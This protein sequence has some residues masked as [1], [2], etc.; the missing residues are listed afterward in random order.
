[1]TLYRP[2]GVLSRRELL[3]SALGA[4]STCLTGCAQLWRPKFADTGW[5]NAV[6]TRCIQPKRELS[7]VS[8]SEIVQYVREAETAGARVRAV[9]AGHSFSDVAFADGW[10]LRTFGLDRTIPLR[11]DRLRAK[12]RGEQLYQ[13]E[14]GIRVRTLNETLLERGLA[15]PNMGGWDHQTL[16]G[17]ISTSTHG[18]GLGYGP[19]PSLVASLVLVT[20]GGRVV[21]FEPSDGITDPLAFHNVVETPCG[22]YPAILVQDDRAFRAALVN[23]GSLGITYSLVL[24]VR[25]AFWLHEERAITTW[26]D[27][28]LPQG[29][30][31]TLLREG[32]PP[33]GWHGIRPEFYEIAVNPYPV[34]GQHTALLTK[35]YPTSTAKA[36]S[37][38]SQR[39][40]PLA[41]FFERF[42][43]K[44]P[45]AVPDALNG[46]PEKAGE[47]L[48]TAMRQGKVDCYESK[49]YDIFNAG[50]TNELPAYSVEM[51]VDFKDT[52][53][54][55]Q[56][57]L[58][59]AKNQQS[60]RA[61]LLSAPISI[62][63]VGQCD[64][65]LSP[66]YRGPTTTLEF[67]SLIGVLGMDTTLLDNET[68]L[69]NDD[70]LLARPHW[71]LDLSAIQGR[72]QACRLFEHF[73]DWHEQYRIYNASGVFN[74]EV[75][76]RLGISVPTTRDR[77]Y[78]CLP[79]GYEEVTVGK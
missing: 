21:Q 34:D 58:N 16:A 29:F 8:L 59:R 56:S 26:E 61:G 27:A 42:G 51:C 69:M 76:D 66:Q 11:Q 31:G 50:P 4:G 65:F 3:F 10:L 43:L 52:L 32:A 53:R 60:I 55:V 77:S 6:H 9:G 20:S 78:R 71:G 35:R 63:F 38:C 44:H 1:M 68:S 49:S 22:A 5:F 54:T 2:T 15:L 74:G 30:V 39:N 57:V 12:Y 13:V 25:P 73:D 24:K 79:V 67:L 47:L 33:V 7:P 70:S 64:A 28:V 17:A 19:F 62:R 14:G 41:N 46:N 37:G 40:T 36:A 18:S 23:M 75:T 48:R 45:Y 72:A